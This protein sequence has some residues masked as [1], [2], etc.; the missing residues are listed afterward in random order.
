MSQVS[1]AN[2]WGGTS[3]PAYKIKLTSVVALRT[4]ATI[5]VFAHYELAGPPSLSLCSRWL[6]L[7]VTSCA[8]YCYGGI[9][10]LPMRERCVETHPTYHRNGFVVLDLA[11]LYSPPFS[12]NR[13][14]AIVA[15]GR[16]FLRDDGLGN[17]LYSAM[18]VHLGTLTPL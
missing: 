7:F 10:K 3:H 13:I 14:P 4:L 16:R 9:I 15:V 12:V 17:G 5:T 2:V 11:A 6:N 8:A 18:W 1:K